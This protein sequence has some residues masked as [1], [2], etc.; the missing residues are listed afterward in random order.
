MFFFDPLDEE[1]EDSRRS[2]VFNNKTLRHAVN[3]LT[4]SEAK[5]GPIG[6]WNV[7]QVT[8][9]STL[10]SDTKENRATFNKPLENWDV[11][12]VV[13]MHCMFFSC[14][15]F[16]Q[17]LNRWNVKKVRDMGLMF[18]RCEVFNQPLNMWNVGNV[19]TMDSMFKGC[20]SFNQDL[21]KWDVSKVQTI[22]GMFDGCEKLNQDF[23][24]WDVSNVR[25]YCSPLLVF[26][27][28]ALSQKHY[29][30][31]ILNWNFT[32]T[33][34]DI[35]GNELFNINDLFGIPIQPDTVIASDYSLFDHPI[36]MTEFAKW[37]I[38]ERANTPSA[39]AGST[40]AM[41]GLYMKNPQLK[42]VAAEVASNWLNID[43][44]PKRMQHILSQYVTKNGGKKNLKKTKKTK[45]LKNMKNMKNKKK[46]KKLKRKPKT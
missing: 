31:I 25:N 46:S 11:S 39:L 4:Q 33:K 24:N 40:I 20:E 13:N 26:N 2:P 7:S 30:D 12:N 27:E 29:T 28:T 35:D 14:Q 10:F 19:E 42:D 5:Y 17:P 37:Q 15:V 45:K 23:S 16:N 38:K 36:R 21:T 32:F 22:D 3:N 41:R 34:L 44:T 1:D 18:N 6:Y 43:R 9:M 8:D